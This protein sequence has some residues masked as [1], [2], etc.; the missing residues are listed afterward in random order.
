MQYVTVTWFAWQVINVTKKCF[1]T[2]QKIRVNEIYCTL[3]TLCDND[4]SFKIAGKNPLIQPIM[5][6][7][8][9]WKNTVTV[10][11]TYVA[12]K[13]IDKNILYK[14]NLWYECISRIKNLFNC[15]LYVCLL[16]ENMKHVFALLSL[17]VL[18][19]F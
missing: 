13:W 6:Y 14:C 3:H 10:Y 1:Y 17:L 16:M 15:V 9:R 2:Q 11:K 7:L 4:M 18:M 12:F 5:M 19:F 8:K